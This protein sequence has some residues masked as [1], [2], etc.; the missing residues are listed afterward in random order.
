MFTIYSFVTVKSIKASMR[1]FFERMR[2]ISLF[3]IFYLGR[4]KMNFEVKIV[5]YKLTDLKKEAQD[6]LLMLGPGSAF[7]G[8]CKAE[9]CTAR[10]WRNL[11]HADWVF[12]DEH[13]YYQLTDEGKNLIR[14]HNRRK[15]KRRW[16]R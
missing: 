12:I 4:H 15:L 13:G 10:I 14:E 11:I 16:F 1:Y 3:T 5:E 8:Y 6:A 9:V 7:E 2:D